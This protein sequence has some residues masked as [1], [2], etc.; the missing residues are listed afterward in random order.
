MTLTI[1]IDVGGTHT[2]AVLISR[3]KVYKKAKIPTDHDDLLDSTLQAIKAIYDPELCKNLSRICLSTTLSTNA[4]VEKTYDKVGL[5]TLP[6]P[7]ISPLNLP[8]FEHSKVLKGYIDHR[9]KVIEDVDE[10]EVRKAVKEFIE[11]G[12]QYIA[13][14]SKFSNRNPELEEKVENLIKKDFP[15]IEYISLGHRVA[16]RLNF[17]RRICTSYF[18]AAIYRRHKSFVESVKNSLQEIGLN[19]PTFILKGDG[20]TLS[21]EDSVKHCVHTIL[22]GPAASILGKMALTSEH[23]SAFL[24]DIGG[25]TTDIGLMLNGSPVFKSGGTE[26]GGYK[27]SVRGLYSQSLGIGGDSAISVENGDLM[28]GPRREGPAILY[29]GPVITPTDAAAY[30]DSKNVIT[31]ADSNYK[32]KR[33]ESE[34]KS[35]GDKLNLSPDE[36]AKK[37]MENSSRIIGDKIL[38]VCRKLSNRPVYTVKEVLEPFKLEVNKLVGIGGP[39]HLFLPYIAKYLET[40]YELAP[41]HE[42]ANAI[43][44][45]VARPTTVVTVHCDTASNYYVIPEMGIK[46]D[47][48]GINDIVSIAKIARNAISERAKRRKGYEEV[49]VSRETEITYTEEFNVVRDFTTIGKIIE[50]GAQIKPGPV[51]TLNNS[52]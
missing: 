2:D 48:E 11:E 23:S 43:G 7:G 16:G 19:A 52:K 21:L 39:A 28:I 3:D 10:D 46:K 12:S 44:A 32:I 50:L 31:D 34:L 36:V 33:I 24:L 29:G 20:G 49:D 37:I 35:L 15:E 17:P 1:G 45:G 6:G 38:D 18:N 40:E 4:I 22:S 42:V 5:L 25:T 47:A 9:G 30:I 51:F 14:V 8:F 27:T 13:V 26:I 41:H